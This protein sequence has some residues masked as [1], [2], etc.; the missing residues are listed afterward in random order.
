MRHTKTTIS[1]TVEFI[2]HLWQGTVAAGSVPF[3]EG[4]QPDWNR[5]AVLE[6]LRH[7]KKV[8]SD[9]TP[10]GDF[11]D[12]IDFSCDFSEGEDDEAKDWESEWER[13]DSLGIYNDCMFPD[14]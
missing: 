6:W 9:L 3:P 1:R 12:I 10:T 11:Q 8:D 4:R 2:G 5:E 7:G 13:E 14:L